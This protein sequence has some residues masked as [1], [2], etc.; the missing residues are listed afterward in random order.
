MNISYD[1]TKLSLDQ[2]NGIKQN[3]ASFPSVLEGPTYTNGNVSITL[4]IGADPTKVAQTPTKVATIT[5]KAK[6]TTNSTPTAVKFVDGQTQV[7]SIASSDQPSENVLSATKPVNIA[8]NASSTTPTPGTGTTPT[9]STTT[10]TPSTATTPAPTTA[11]KANAAPTCTS[12]TFDRAASGTAPFAITLTAN[13]RDSDGTIS[14]VT[15]NFG[16]G[17]VQDVT[18]SGGIGTNTVSTPL[19]HTYN[20]AGTYQAS[21]VLI[22]NAGAISSGTCTQTITVSAATANGGGGT[23]GGTGGT[24]T[25]LPATGGG[26]AEPTTAPTVPTP[27]L[28]PSGP[29]DTVLAGG[30]VAAIVS[31]VGVVM[32]FAL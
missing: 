19:A 31:I 22:D 15:F 27:T 28:K 32:F 5:F 16:D 21:V 1:A 20:N 25:Q 8:I 26:G 24:P 12:L 30:V 11:Q 10:P 9:P 6:D 13:G 23:T 7:L 14:K 4:S 3:D 17:P 18:Q 29:G 2:T